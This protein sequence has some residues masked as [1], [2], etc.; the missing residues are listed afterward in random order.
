MERA[1]VSFFDVD[2]TVHMYLNVDLHLDSTVHMISGMLILCRPYG[3]YFLECWP[4]YG[5]YVTQIL[6]FIKMEI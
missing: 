5:P 2:R 4:I 1:D 3:L 6:L